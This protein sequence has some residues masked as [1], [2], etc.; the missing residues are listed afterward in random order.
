MNHDNYLDRKLKPIGTMAGIENCNHQLLRRTYG[1]HAQNHGSIKSTQRLM[2]HA[3]ADTTLKH[4][5]HVIEE[6][7][8]RAQAS[9]DAALMGW[10]GSGHVN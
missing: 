1:T 8:V 10:K 2:R 3:N 7:V 5:Q 9:W 4:Y 6:D